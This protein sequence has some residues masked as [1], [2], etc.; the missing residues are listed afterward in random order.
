VEWEEC[1]WSGKSL[2]GVGRVLSG[3]GRVLSGVR[4][5]LVVVTLA[6]F[7]YLFL[8]CCT[9]FAGSKVSLV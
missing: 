2:S 4:R 9:L 8:D 3:V 5:V 6:W 7:T 1:K